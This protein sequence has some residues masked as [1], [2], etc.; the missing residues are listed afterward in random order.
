MAPVD[1][2]QGAEPSTAGESYTDR[3]LTL[4]SSGLRRFIP[5]QAPYRA[6][7]RGLKLGRTLDVGCG[8]GRNL[9]H[10]GGNGVGVDHNPHSIA[11]ARARGL[12]AYT[13]DEFTGSEDAKPGSFDSMLIAHVLEH[14]DAE[15][16]SEMIKSYLP[17]IRPQGKVV[18]ITPQEAG[19]AS[20]STHIRWVDFAVLRQTAADTGVETR[21][22][23]SFT[24]PRFTGKL[25]RYNEFVFIGSAPSA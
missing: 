4:E 8:L 1:T 19:Y 21:R 11:A 15:T 18:L 24:L 17:Y 10:I 23:Y 13:P 7:L 12:T 5:V 22:T 6:H 25:F 2:P 3:L 9:L 16:A 20:D 14:I